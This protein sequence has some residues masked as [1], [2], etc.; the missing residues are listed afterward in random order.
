MHPL[1]GQGLNLGLQDVTSLLNTLAQSQASEPH[2]AIH[3]HVLLRRYERACATPTFEI[4]SVTHAL[5]RL[6]A[7]HNPVLRQ[8]RNVGMNALDIIAPLKQRLIQQ[9]M[10]HSANDPK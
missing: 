4:Q 1:A 6:F 9:A 2:R 10:G 8:L 5:Q 7:S 3:D